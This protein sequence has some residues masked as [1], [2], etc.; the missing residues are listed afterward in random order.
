MVTSVSPGAEQ[1]SHWV[2]HRA[3]TFLELTLLNCKLWLC[4]SRGIAEVGSDEFSRSV[5]KDGKQRTMLNDR[6]GQST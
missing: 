3:T 1:V 4:Q 2:P 6:A 5:P